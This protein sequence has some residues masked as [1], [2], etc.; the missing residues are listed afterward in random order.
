MITYLVSRKSLLT[1]ITKQLTSQI[2]TIRRNI[3]KNII[4][5]SCWEW[6]KFHFAPITECMDLLYSRYFKTSYSFRMVNDLPASYVRP[7]FQG[8]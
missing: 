2:T 4:P 6:V 8:S 1:L 7:E 5:K 3:G